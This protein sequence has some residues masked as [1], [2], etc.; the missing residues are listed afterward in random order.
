MAA[1]EL[2]YTLLGCLKELCYLVL[3]TFRNIGCSLVSNPLLCTPWSSAWVIK[4][5]GIW[6]LQEMEEEPH[7]IISDTFL[8]L[9]VREAAG[10]RGKRNLTGRKKIKADKERQWARKII[11]M[12]KAT[13]W[14]RDETSLQFQN[15]IAD[16]H[17]TKKKHTK[18]INLQLSL[19]SLAD[20]SQAHMNIK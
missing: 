18:P 7:F 13:V 10:N 6:H 14:E 16:R 5:Q 9:W 4:S 2:T 1:G 12:R 17:K 20:V 15:S 3:V 11:E 8:Y 19:E